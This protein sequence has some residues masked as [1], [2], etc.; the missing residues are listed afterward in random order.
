[1]LKPEDFKVRERNIEQL[2]AEMEA[3]FDSAI[4][5]AHRADSWPALVTVRKPDCTVVA[6]V[7]TKY[8]Q[9]GWRVGSHAITIGADDG[10]QLVADILKSDP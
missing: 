10:P 9:A 6:R 8:R 7:I 2:C 1:M 4:N 5:E 3:A